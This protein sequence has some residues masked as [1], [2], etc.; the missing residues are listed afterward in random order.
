VVTT[1]GAG[2]LDPNARSPLA[3][4]TAVDVRNRYQGTWVRG[5]EVAEST[6]EGYR[7]R[8]LSDGSILPEWFSRDDIRRQR[9]RQ[10]YWWH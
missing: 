1:G 2:P 6:D 3:V 5:F 8:R 7:L 9:S 4:G 10:G